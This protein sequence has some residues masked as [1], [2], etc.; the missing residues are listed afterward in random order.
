MEEILGYHGQ[1]SSASPAVGIRI[2]KAALP[3]MQP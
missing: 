3:R 2:Y 1:F